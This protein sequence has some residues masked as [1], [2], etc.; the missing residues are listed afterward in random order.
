MLDYSPANNVAGWQW[1][2]GG[3][4]AAPY[5]IFNPILQGEKF[6]KEGEYVKMGA[7]IKRYTKKIYTQTLGIK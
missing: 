3:A 1:V 2:A 6:D 7:R 4:D 5:L